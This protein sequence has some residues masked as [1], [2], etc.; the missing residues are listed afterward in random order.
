[1]SQSWGHSR[2]Q[3]LPGIWASTSS[4]Q[5]ASAGPGVGRSLWYLSC[6]KP[7]SQPAPMAVPTHREK[8]G[9]ICRGRQGLLLPCRRSQIRVEQ[10]GLHREAVP[11]GFRKAR[12][13]SGVDKG[14]SAFFQACWGIDF[15]NADFI[16][17]RSP[18]MLPV[19]PSCITLP[20]LSPAVG[21]E[22]LSSG[23]CAAGWRD[24]E[25]GA[26]MPGER[27]GS[28]QAGCAPRWAVRAVLEAR[29]DPEL[30]SPS[31]VPPPISLSLY[32]LPCP[33]VLWL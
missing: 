33:P 25:A 20:C 17:M 13:S 29:P 14:F 11:A 8:A 28:S 1:M 23:S 9:L 16:W 6:P 26:E 32:S 10:V 31:P 4:H 18:M 21:T 3:L 22:K 24:T 19:L 30:L 15:I 7:P 2:Y 27:P 12:A 5:T